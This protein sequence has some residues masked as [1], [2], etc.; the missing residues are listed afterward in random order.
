M[1]DKVFFHCLA[2]FLSFTFIC[3]CASGPEGKEDGQKKGQ[4]KQAQKVRK[5]RKIKN[6][7]VVSNKAEKKGDSA[8]LNKGDNKEPKLPK[9][10]PGSAIGR[11]PE[12]AKKLEDIAKNYTFYQQKQK[13]AADHYYKSGLAHY[14][15]LRY[16]L[17]ERDLL[18]CLQNDPNHRD[19]K[20]LLQRVRYIL[21]DKAGP[22]HDLARDYNQEV[23]IKI[24]QTKIEIERLLSRAKLNFE[25]KN[26]KKAKEQFERILEMAQWFP[27]QVVDEAF[28][29]Q[30]KNWIRRTEKAKR[31]Y[32]LELKRKLQE[33]A[34]NQARFLHAQNLK[35]VAARIRALYRQATLAYQQEEYDTV[36]NICDEILDLR[37]QF[38]KARI[39]KQRAINAKHILK[40]RQ[41][42]KEQT[43]HF[44][45]QIEYVDA[46]AI[47]YQEVFR[48]PDR[49]KW[50]VIMN[51]AVQVTSFVEEEEVSAK[52]ADINA[53]LDNQ[54]IEVNF[55]DVAFM[56]AIDFLRQASGLTIVLS[57][58][59]KQLVVDNNLRISSLPLPRAKL[60]NALEFILRVSPELTYKVKYGAV[61]ITTKGSEKKKMII[62]YYNVSDIINDLPNFPA[63]KLALNAGG[64]G[65][66]GAAGP[67]L[68][69]EEGDEEGQTTGQGVGKEKLIELINKNIGESEDEGSV[70]ISNGVLIVRKPLEAHK[71]IQKLLDAL[72]K[73]VGIMVTIETKFI[74]IQDNLLEEVG[75]DYRGLSTRIFNVDGAG[76]NQDVGY[77]RLSSSGNNDIRSALVNIISDG[78][79]TKA[80]NPFN[81][82]NIGGLAVQYQKL[83]SF[84]LN[85]ILEAVKKKQRA[86]IVNAPRLNVFN[87]QRAHVL[88]IRQRS[89]IKDITVDSAGVVPVLNPEI[90]I[91]NS[92]SILDA[93]PT[94]SYDKKYVTL[95]IRPTLAVDRTTAANTTTLNLANGNTNIPLELPILTVQKIRTTV[96]VPDGGTILLGGLKNYMRQKK[97]AG[98]PILSSIPF[99]KALVSRRAWSHLRRSLIVLLTVKIHVIRDW[100]KRQFGG[101]H[102]K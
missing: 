46:A 79:G 74:D 3:G 49:E 98:V 33:A 58:S 61:Y 75:V 8:L 73:T 27:Y 52:E 86:R 25:Q 93:R 76:T 63:P 89:Y 67:G 36:I 44:A 4:N 24:A 26:Y 54:T 38:T 19:A 56:E 45:R 1:K 92:G 12:E 81:I 13:I 69:P 39:L 97:I 9:F 23:N 47:P 83:S 72:R 71:K 82:Q 34:E 64:Q 14:K 91:L 29:S 70:K 51:R 21:G 59:A 31:S 94:V 84:Q 10:V 16:R 55:K 41:N 99:I 57:N 101:L 62:H 66:G 7:P 37:P 43:E 11:S 42:I 78:I 60:R 22:I 100:E 2:I 32:D 95:E 28:I 90:G 6:Q 5:V 65:G 35:Y 53:R 18:Q 20:L 88:S 50:K 96:T 30:I 68:L 102:L 87:T 80:S 17:A 85:A 77:R 40:T 15:A 48:F